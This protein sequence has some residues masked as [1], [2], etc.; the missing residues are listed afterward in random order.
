MKD[1]KGP[2][3]IIQRITGTGICMIYDINESAGVP[4]YYQVQINLWIQLIN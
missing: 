4:A 1:P 2:Q 3:T